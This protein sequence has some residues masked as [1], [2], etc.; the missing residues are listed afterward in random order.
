M[1]QI[2]VTSDTFGMS[3]E[4]AQIRLVEARQVMRERS[5]ELARA[6]QARW[7]GTKYVVTIAPICEVMIER[8]LAKLIDELARLGRAS[9][10]VLE[11]INYEMPD[12]WALASLGNAALRDHIMAAQENPDPHITYRQADLRELNDLTAPVRL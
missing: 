1:T 6:G 3:T 8:H 5:A 4:L 12:L 11:L 10:V 9:G 7:T 2:L